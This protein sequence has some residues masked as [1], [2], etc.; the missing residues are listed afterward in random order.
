MAFA[1]ILKLWTLN[2]DGV[3]GVGEFEEVNLPK[4]EREMKDYIAGG[5]ISPVKIAMGLKLL[6]VEITPGGWHEAA[7][8]ALGKD[9]LDGVALMF[10][11]SMQKE[12]SGEIVSVEIH[13]RG[14]AETLERDN[15]KQGDVSKFKQKLPL[16]YYK[17][18]WAGKT[19][20]EVDTLNTVFVINSKDLYAEHKA[21]IGGK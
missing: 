17:E 21:N 9:T 7:L 19:K 1:P 3:G 20:I 15:L 6:E 14:R 16:V 18:I 12:D 11:G 13:M 10:L 2:I 5:M 8:N 4:I